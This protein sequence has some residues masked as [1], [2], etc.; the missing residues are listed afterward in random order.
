[1]SPVSLFHNSISV[2]LARYLGRLVQSSNAGQVFFDSVTIRLSPEVSRVPDVVFVSTANSRAA[3]RENHIDGPPDLII[4]I[5]S[6]ESRTRDYL[7]KY[8]DYE[9]A[10]VTEY[11]IIDPTYQTID[12]YRL[13]NARYERISPEEPNPALP[14]TST[15]LPGFVLK[16]EWLKQNPLPNP[17][18]FV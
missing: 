8:H 1:M 12:L 2:F 11:W 18:Q 6:P 10:G 17:D 15:V 3:M 9:S 16:A 14:L 4:E 13:K 5:V 7:D